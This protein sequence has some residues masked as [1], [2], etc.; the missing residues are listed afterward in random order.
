MHVRIV[1]LIYIALIIGTS[2]A[3]PLSSGWC[4]TGRLSMYVTEVVVPCGPTPYKWLVGWL[5]ASLDCTDHR[6]ESLP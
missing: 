6:F 3:K 4:E 1:C 5:V 2:K